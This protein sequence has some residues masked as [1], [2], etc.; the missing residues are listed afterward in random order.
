MKKILLTTLF[1]SFA[2]STFEEYKQEG[3]IG[4]SFSNEQMLGISGL[5]KFDKNIGLVVSY[6]LRLESFARESGD[7]FYDRSYTWAESF[8]DDL[9]ETNIDYQSIA[10]SLAHVREK[11]TIYAGIGHTDKSEYRRYYDSYH[12]LG[13]DGHY[14]VNGTGHGGSAYFNFGLMIKIPSQYND[15]TYLF[16]ESDTYPKQISFGAFFG[17]RDKTEE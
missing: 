10:L 13:D 2:F 6:K 7:D 4:F 11:F 17:F 8:G 3:R 16:I 14:W 1:L 12:I 9:R 5:F 15:Q